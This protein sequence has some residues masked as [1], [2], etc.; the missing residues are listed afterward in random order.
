MKTLRT[1]LTPTGDIDRRA[2][3]RDAH[4]EHAYA[5]RKGW[6]DPAG[7]DPVTWPQ[8]LRASIARARRERELKLLSFAGDAIR[9]MLKA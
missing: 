9:E 8:T 2:V 5:R 1:L 7:E 3:L 6:T 4:R